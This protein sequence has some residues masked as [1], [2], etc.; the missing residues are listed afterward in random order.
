MPSVILGLI[1]LTVGLF[2]ATAWWWS[3]TEFL[4]GA[5]STVS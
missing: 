2:G 5:T 1:A 3:V 4:R